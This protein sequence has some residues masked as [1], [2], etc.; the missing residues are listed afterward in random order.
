MDE[1]RGRQVPCG[2]QVLSHGCKMV[3]QHC[4]YGSLSRIYTSTLFNTAVHTIVS[5]S[6]QQLYPACWVP[7]A[8]CYPQYFPL[9]MQLSKSAA[10][11]C[12]RDVQQRYSISECVFQRHTAVN[13]PNL[14]EHKVDVKRW[15]RRR[16][17]SMPES[18]YL[19]WA[20]PRIVLSLRGD[21][22]LLPVPQGHAEY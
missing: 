20:E 11:R 13:F 19:S 6:N 1:S 14:R 18:D 9:E 5:V 3:E 2:A 21:R 7:Y 12:E 10:L 22:S 8:I 16:V 4:T 15:D 17:S